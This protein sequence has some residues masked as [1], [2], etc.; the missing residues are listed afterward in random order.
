MI[1]I[2]NFHVLN[3]VLLIYICKL[4]WN[5][6]NLLLSATFRAYRKAT[7]KKGDL[8]LV[9]RTASIDLS[10]ELERLVETG[11]FLNSH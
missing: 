8:E 2:C 9:Y 5:Q 10:D 3:H 4:H 6:L 1:H 11:H 7:S